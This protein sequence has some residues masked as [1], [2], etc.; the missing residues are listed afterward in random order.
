MRGVLP[1]VKPIVV[2]SC[3]DD[4]AGGAPRERSSASS[5]LGA[6]AGGTRIRGQSAGEYLRTSIVMSDNDVVD[7]L[8]AGRLQSEGLTDA[9]IDALLTHLEDQ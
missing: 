9:E 2:S 4:R 1:L 8:H 6:Q 7:E 3:G 5:V